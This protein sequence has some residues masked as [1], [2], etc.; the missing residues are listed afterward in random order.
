MD[1]LPILVRVAELLDRHKLEAILIG[2]AAAALQGAPVTTI[3]I[4]FRFC[5]TPSNV[6]KLKAI[7]KE[8]NAVLLRPYYP[9]SPLWRISCD[10]DG[11]QLDFMNAIDGVRSFDGLRKRSS[12]VTIGGT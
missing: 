7:A 4:D 10:S 8:L 6:R 1:A 12:Q 11:L 2:N 5:R 3:D 9:A